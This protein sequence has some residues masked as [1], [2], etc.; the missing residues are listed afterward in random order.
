MRHVEEAQSWKVVVLEKTLLEELLLDLLDL[1]S[2]HATAIG[3]E[4]AICLFAE[5]GEFGF[6]RCGEERCDEFFFE[7]RQGAIEVFQGWRG[8]GGLGS[9]PLPLAVRGVGGVEGVGEVGEAVGGGEGG[10]LGCGGEG[11]VA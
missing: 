10:G 8:T 4:F 7:D 1:M 3:R 11:G 6:G 5:S 9:I 2:L